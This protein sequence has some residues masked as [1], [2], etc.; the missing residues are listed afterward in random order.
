[1]K[2]S[3]IAPCLWIDTEAKEAA[4][5]YVDIFKNSKTNSI[6][7]Y[8]NEGREIH[9]EKEGHVMTVLFELDGQICTTL[10]GVPL[11]KFNKT[12]SLQIYREAQDEIN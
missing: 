7:R 10:D 12:V 6:A 9:A 3:K 4:N 11:F 1:M 5:Y 2:L 8:G